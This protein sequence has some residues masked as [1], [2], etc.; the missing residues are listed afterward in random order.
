MLRDVDVKTAVIREKKYKLHDSGGLYIE[1]NPSGSKIWR[2]KYKVAKKENVLT[3]GPYPE[4]TLSA[5]RA[6]RDD[7][8]KELRGGRNPSLIKKLIRQSATSEEHQF[9]R[10][11]RAWYEKEKPGWRARHTHDVITSLEK[12]VFPVL[13]SVD[14]R[15]ITS[16]MFYEVLHSIEKRPAIETAHRVHQRIN[17]I[18]T[19]AVARGLAANNLAA[20]VKV[21]LAKVERRGK[22]PALVD[23]QS[24][25]Q[26]MR[27]V[28]S[29]IAHPTTKLALYLLA[30][31]AVRP[32]EIREAKWS[33][34]I[35]D[36]DEPEWKIPATRMKMGKEHFVPLSRQSADVIQTVKKLSGS[37]EY[38]FVNTRFNNRSM[39]EN[40]MGYL[41]NRAGYHSRHVPH[42]FRSSFSTI[43]NE[44]I[45]DRECKE[46]T[47][48]DRVVI[49]L[50]LAHEN[51]I[52]ASETAYNRAEMRQRRREIAQYWADLLLDDVPEPSSLL[53]GPRR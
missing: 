42:G 14:I 4:V 53:N 2:M 20:G 38:L 22:Q 17:A 19:Y 46:L 9:E 30:L 24:V 18:C 13:G 39:S 10:V 50:M 28:A 3:F 47:E 12:Y 34:F 15:E 8:R 48:A 1:V 41:L 37:S 49:D 27:D 26:I 31:T 7:A 23:L 25:Q 45:S 29:E 44:R 6:A 21:A 33:E 36:T 35:L 11:A 40:A 43:L 51:K 5:A 32:G 52:S 16:N